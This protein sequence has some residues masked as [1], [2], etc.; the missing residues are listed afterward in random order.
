MKD[1]DYIT[2]IR[3]KLHKKPEL[4]NQEYY[5]QEEILKVLRGLNI[6]F[7]TAGTGVIARLN[8]NK[9]KTIA[10]RC[11]MDALPMLEKNNVDFKSENQN[12]HACGHDGHM[13]IM[14][15]F[16][17]WVSENKDIIKHNM[18]FI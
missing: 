18:V 16:V 11:E 8:L 2:N 1:L 3:R 12:M 9:E 14:L 5:A 4:S 7:E 15:T 13:A 17:K 10:Y 6:E